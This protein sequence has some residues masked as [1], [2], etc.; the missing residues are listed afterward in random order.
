MNF[1]LGCQQRSRNGSLGPGND[2]PDQSAVCASA[3]GFSQECSRLFPVALKLHFI[4]NGR[5]LKSIDHYLPEWIKKHPVLYPIGGFLVILF[6]FYLTV[7]EPIWSQ[8]TDKLFF[9][10]VYSLL[11]GEL[12]LI[13]LI[14]SGLFLVAFVLNL[15]F[16]AG[17]AWRNLRRPKLPRNTFIKVGGGK[18]RSRSNEVY[19]AGDLLKPTKDELAAFGDLLK[20]PRQLAEAWNTARGKLDTQIKITEE[21]ASKLAIAEQYENELRAEL[22]ERKKVYR[23][24]EMEAVLHTL[25][26]KKET[27]G[28]TVT[29]VYMQYP[30]IDFAEQIAGVFRHVGWNAETKMFVGEKPPDTSGPV[31]VQSGSESLA[32]TVLKAIDKGGL[33]GDLSC[34]SFPDKS[35]QPDEVVITLFPKVTS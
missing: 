23:R 5:M 35:L 14:F 29:V 15:F 20:T 34:N 11:S 16:L 9:Q 12:G 33:L 28:L 13:V 30:E 26:L 31:L 8:S 18:H 22:S 21:V 3:C 1:S 17:L 32:D 27:L 24:Y 2:P 7:F 25:N 4:H 10:E 6:L 19:E